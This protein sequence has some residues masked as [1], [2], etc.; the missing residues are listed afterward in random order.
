MEVNMCVYMCTPPPQRPLKLNTQKF[1]PLSLSSGILD[2]FNFLL[3]SC[4]APRISMLKS[5]DTK[6]HRGYSHSRSGSLGQ[7]LV[8][9]AIAYLNHGTL[10]A[11]T[12]ASAGRSFVGMSRT[13]LQLKNLYH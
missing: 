5:V 10:K 6:R 2:N 8:W 11:T 13:T 9:A 1:K 7:F 4:Q 12:G 3:H